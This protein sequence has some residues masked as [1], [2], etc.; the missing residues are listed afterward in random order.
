VYFVRFV[1]A[2]TGKSVD[3]GV[4]ATLSLRSLHLS[5]LALSEAVALTAAST[6]P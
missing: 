4:F 6:L 2:M 5:I 1:V 3:V